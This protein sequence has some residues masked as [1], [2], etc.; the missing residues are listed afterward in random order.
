MPIRMVLSTPR[1]R[2]PETTARPRLPITRPT[3]A[4]QISDQATDSANPSR[5]NPNAIISTT[6]TS[7]IRT[8][9]MAA[10]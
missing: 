1:L 7:R 9:D 3:T 5:P 2:L 6:R 10:V 8:T 4:Y